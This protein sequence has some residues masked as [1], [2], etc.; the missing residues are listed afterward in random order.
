[1]GLYGRTL[2][3]LY[4]ACA[5]IPQNHWQRI[6]QRIFHRLSALILR[7]D[8]SLLEQD[9]AGSRLLL[10]FSHRLP[11]YLQWHPWY[12]SNVARIARHVQ[13]KYPDLTLV[14]VGANVGDTIALV[15]R[16][17]HCPILCLEG[18]GKFFG[19]LESNARRF[20][21]VEVVNEFLGDCDQEVPGL[22]VQS[23]G[24][25]H[26]TESTTGYL[27]IRRLDALLKER[28][29]FWASKFIKI[30]TDGYDA[31]V[32][33]GAEEQLAAVKPVLFFEYDP[34]FLAQQ[35]EEP[36]DLLSNLECLGYSHLIFYDNF[37]ELLLDAE[38]G[39]RRQL[40]EITLYFTGRMAQRYCDVCAFHSVDTDLFET[41][42]AAELQ[43]FRDQKKASIP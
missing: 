39:N 37:G 19:I 5:R 17:I 24:S 30:D 18:D 6:G 36:L 7:F 40:E 34:H 42:I 38:I 22:L 16:E 23:D 20:S 2:H 21:D 10:P 15:R 41:V 43:L 4:G 3:F 12:S 11:M 27:T 35:H 14:D 28:P 33:R 13:A 32:I 25:A 26:V 1:M 9:I 8:D 31:K 29:R